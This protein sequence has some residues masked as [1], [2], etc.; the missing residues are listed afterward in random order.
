M[1]GKQTTEMIKAHTQDHAQNNGN[2]RTKARQEEKYGEKKYKENKVHFFF[3]KIL[4]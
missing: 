3:R 2:K 1:E 4:P